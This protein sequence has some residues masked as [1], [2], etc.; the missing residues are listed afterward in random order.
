MFIYVKILQRKV[1]CSLYKTLTFIL[2]E[3]RRYWKQ[4]YLYLINKYSISLF[5]L[6]RNSKGARG[7]RIREM[8]EAHTMVLRVVRGFWP[9]DVM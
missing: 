3:I 6:L 2:S 1:S 9:L 5:C 7:E 8:K 4:I